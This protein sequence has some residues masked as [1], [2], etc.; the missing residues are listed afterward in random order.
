MDDVFWDHIALRQIVVL[1]TG[2]S[3]AFVSR[4]ILTR[5]E[6]EAKSNAGLD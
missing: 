5:K 2:T 1:E 3:R 4:E 6:Q